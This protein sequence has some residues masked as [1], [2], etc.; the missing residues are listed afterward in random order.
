MD[1]FNWYKRRINRIYPTVFTWALIAAVFFDQRYDMPEILIKGGGWFVSCIMIYYVVL[2]F[3]R[4][5]LKKHLKWVFFMAATITL[6]WYFVLGFGEKAVIICMDG[7][8]LNGAIIS[9]LCF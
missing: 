4:K 2:W 9:Y 8:T 6:L 5:F 1:F 7:I 3:I